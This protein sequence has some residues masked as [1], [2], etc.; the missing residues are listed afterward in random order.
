MFNS[1]QY[2]A[3]C[4]QRNNKDTVATMH[5]PFTIIIGHQCEI[6]ITRDDMTLRLKWSIFH[7]ILSLVFL[8]SSL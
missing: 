7:E 4:R 1:H 3:I 2:L 8:D 6:G 5:K